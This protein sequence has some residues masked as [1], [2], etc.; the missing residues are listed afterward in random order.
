MTRRKLTRSLLAALLAAG[1][2]PVA[3]AHD[4][5]D[6]INAVLDDTADA[7]TTSPMRLQPEPTIAIDPSDPDIIA[8]GAQDFRKT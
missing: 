3:A 8:A 6:D 4:D 7:L 5:S 1:L 2:V